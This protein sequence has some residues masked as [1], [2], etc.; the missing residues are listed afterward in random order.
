M[1]L[2]TYFLLLF[3]ATS[4]GLSG[5]GY[6][7]YIGHQEAPG[8][9]FLPEFVDQVRDYESSLSL[10]HRSE[11]WIPVVV[12][13][14]T[15]DPYAVTYAKVL[16]QIDI[17][18]SDFAGRG[19][20]VF[21]LPDEFDEL[22]ADTGIRF[23]LADADPEGNPSSGV[24]YTTTDIT[25]I[26]LQRDINGRYVLYY[27]Q[28]GGKTGWDPER[29]INIWI[30]SF[31]NGLIGFATLPGT[32]N[33][34]EETGIVIDPSAFGSLG[35]DMPF[36]DR[37]H[38]LTHEMGHYLGLLH[39]WG[40][41]NNSC[42]DSDEIDDTPNAAGPYLGCPD[43]IQISCGESNMYQ[44][45]MDL[46]DDRCLAAFTHDQAM[47][48]N[49]TIGIFYPEIFTSSPCI[50]HSE[51]FDAWWNGL[52]WAYESQSREYV[53]YSEADFIAAI[54]IDVFS[55]DGRRVLHD[56]WYGMQTYLIDIGIPGV[57]FVRL[58]NGNSQHVRKISVQ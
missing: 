18:N 53:I 21:K 49:A 46:T 8:D 55:T 33:F 58:L 20:N 50:D 2:H 57:Y 19:E 56:E 16:H 7:C 15:D 29:Y 1:K 25:G 22:V 35:P 9:S 24:T 32:A 42:E 51:D 44:N 39:I 37:G 45:F 6:W 31:G 43:G 52:T 34:P 38:T 17:L 36:I 11:K 12:H 3:I 23:C 13:V 54:T 28:L 5:Q 14:V 30:A 40:S 10:Q 4:F 27:D 26:A 41:E 47:R 48:M